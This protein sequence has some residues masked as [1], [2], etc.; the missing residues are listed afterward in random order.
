MSMPNVLRELE[1]S[2]AMHESNARTCERYQDRDGM[3]LAQE[4]AREYRPAITA[5]NDH[6]RRQEAAAE[7]R[8]RG[9][10]A[11]ACACEGASAS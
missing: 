1:Q 9:E 3:E 4:R 8:K 6:L 7:R 2:A 11:G 10:T 5:L